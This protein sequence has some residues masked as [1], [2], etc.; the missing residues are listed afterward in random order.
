MMCEQVREHLPDYLVQAVDKLTEAE[1]QD[2]LQSCPWCREEAATWDRLALLP[3]EPPGPALRTRFEAM[4]A[5]YREGVEHAAPARPRPRFRLSGWL[6]SWWPH[7]PAFQFG[8]AMF[9]L[10]AGGFAGYLVTAA[11]PKNRE[12]ARLRE[13]VQNTRQLVALA[14]LQQQSASERLRGVTWSTRVAQPDEEVL[15]ALLQVLKYDPSVDVRLA[16]VDAL[17]RYSSEPAARNGMVEA[18][19]GQQSPL[20]QIALIDLVV[21]LR[22]RQA[23]DVLNRIQHDKETNEIV[24]QRAAWALKQL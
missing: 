17:R 10:V 13:E 14:L 3:A 9:C 23:V 1:I 18:L 24:R 11:G 21:E 4:L 19:G 6:E 2:H 12:L 5:A 8:I 7:Q 20:V 16:A 15:A 22:N